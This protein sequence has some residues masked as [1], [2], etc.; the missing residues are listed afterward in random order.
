MNAATENRTHMVMRLS[1]DGV[2]GGVGA[3]ADGRRTRR[4]LGD[5]SMDVGGADGD[6]R[7]VTAGALGLGGCRWSRCSI[8]GG[9][10]SEPKLTSCPDLAGSKAGDA[11]TGGRG[12]VTASG[13]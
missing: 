13:D 4:G 5:S 9:G 12:T 7:C 10:V 1:R 8:T 6:N 2:A 11:A 3:Y